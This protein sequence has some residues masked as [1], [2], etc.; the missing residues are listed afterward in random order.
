LSLQTSVSIPCDDDN[1]KVWR[2]TV[3]VD[4]TQE[5]WASCDK[6][7]EKLLLTGI[8]I[9]SE[10]KSSNYTQDFEEEEI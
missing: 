4:N 10:S 3:E 5:R 9:I 7:R 1:P 2:H 8:K 6:H